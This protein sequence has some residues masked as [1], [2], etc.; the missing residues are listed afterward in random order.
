MQ[1]SGKRRASSRKPRDP[2]DVRFELSS[3]DYLERFHVSLYLE[4][5]IKLL[6]DCRDE[7]PLEFIAEY[8]NSMQRG[9]H[10]LL[11]EFAYINA[12]TVEDAL[13]LLGLLCPDF[14]EALVRM[15]ARLTSPV[16]RGSS[17]VPHGGDKYDAPSLLVNLRC[18]L[19]YSEFLTMLAAPFSRVKPGAGASATEQLLQEIRAIAEADETSFSCPAMEV[20]ERCAWPL[21]E[22]GFELSPGMSLVDEFM[23]ALAID[24]AVED[25]FGIAA[26]P[27]AWSPSRASEGHFDGAELEASAAPKLPAVATQGAGKS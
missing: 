8:F 10:V 27:E 23:M 18:L 25:L 22:A 6:L 9:D 1:G 11:R 3:A 21:L 20:V 7:R 24:P 14:P 26:Q 13:Q 12:V 16:R 19:Y 5:A 17:E 15:A 4:D 2:E